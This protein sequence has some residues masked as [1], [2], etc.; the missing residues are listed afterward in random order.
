MLQMRDIGGSHGG[1]SW[2]RRGRRSIESAMDGEHVCLLGLSS[3]KTGFQGKSN[4]MLQVFENNPALPANIQFETGPIERVQ[5]NVPSLVGQKCMFMDI[6]SVELDVAKAVCPVEFGQY[7]GRERGNHIVKVHLRVEEE[8]PDMKHSI[9][10]E[11]AY[12]AVIQVGSI[13]VSRQE[14]VEVVGD[15]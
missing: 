1:S 13:L 12:C 8:G 4:R 2:S 15:V 7:S 6:I 9:R 3:L 5:I 10:T 14:F 11:E